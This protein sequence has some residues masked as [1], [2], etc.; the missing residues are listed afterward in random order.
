MSTHSNVRTSTYALI[1]VLLI[2]A[3]PVSMLFGSCLLAIVDT[4]IVL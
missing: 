2:T 4:D 1:S 3:S